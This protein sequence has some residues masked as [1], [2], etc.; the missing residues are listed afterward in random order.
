MGHGRAYSPKHHLKTLFMSTASA[1]PDTLQLGHQR[2]DADHDEFIALAQQLRQAGADN[3][4]AAHDALAAHAR[5]H[6]ALEDSLMAPHDFASKEC[7]VDEHAA[8]LAS[9]DE[10]RTV[11]LQGR[12]ELAARFADRLIAWLPEHVDALDRHLAKF[13]FFQQTGGAPVLIRR[14]SPQGTP[15]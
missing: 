13:I 8:V 11:L 2:L 3:V 5:A 14:T 9:F 15:C 12:T 1:T 6:F 4:V 10:V 7:H